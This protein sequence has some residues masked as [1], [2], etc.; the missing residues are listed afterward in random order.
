MLRCTVSCV[1]PQSVDRYALHMGKETDI[2]HVS[3]DSQLTVACVLRDISV[4]LPMCKTYL[5]LCPCARHI[6]SFAHVQDTRVSY[7]TYESCETPCLS[8]ARDTTRQSCRRRVC[9]AHGQRDRYVLHMG[10]G[11]DMSCE[12]PCLSQDESHSTYEP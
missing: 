10:K 6:C 12:T 7:K 8:P 4:P 11:I 9:L 1:S 3:A 2:S 5:S